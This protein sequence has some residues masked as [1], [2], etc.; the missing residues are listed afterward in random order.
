MNTAGKLFLALLLALLLC[1]AASANVVYTTVDNSYTSGTLGMFD[2]DM[3]V[4]PNLVTN[5][6]GDSA[7][8]SFTYGGEDRVA[9]VDHNY[10]VGDRV[11]IY[12]PAQGWNRPLANESWAGALNT[13][14]MTAVGGY[15]YAACYNSGTVVQATLPEGKLTG[16][17]WACPA[18]EGYTAH[19]E[20]VLSDGTYLYALFS[21]EGGSYPDVT[22]EPSRV[23]RMNADLTAVTEF[24]VGK[25]AT[26]MVVW[27]DKLAVACWGGPQL[28]GTSG[29][30]DTLDP[31][32]GTVTELTDGNGGITSLCNADGTLYFIRQDYKAA[33]DVFPV[34]TL[35]KWTG[36]GSVAVRDI[37]STSGYTY[38]VAYDS[39]NGNIVTTAGDRVL[40][41]GSD[42]VLKKTFL[43][44]ELGGNIYSIAV[45]AG[46]SVDPDDDGEDEDD[47]GSGCDAF[48][49]PGALVL[50][51]P[52]MALRRRK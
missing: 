34:S 2:G 11:M 20:R 15:L 47:G 48:A 50:A 45:I 36:T 22:Y 25:N 43:N 6:T 13:H 31:K 4:S 32:T 19:A 16:R 46:G 26:D 49:G 18:P 12:D 42:D 38:Q 27:G 28:F 5:L 52:L 35:C 29:G 8:F 1:G 37:S 41:L 10:D 14:G 24:E 23:I 44:P 17:S 9:V 33:A 30:I 3:A 7:A 21:L 40:V 39:A 51:V